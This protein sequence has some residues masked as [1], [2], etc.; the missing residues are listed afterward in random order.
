MSVEMMVKVE[1]SAQCL[2]HH[3]LVAAVLCRCGSRE[4]H[5]GGRRKEGLFSPA[6][7][8]RRN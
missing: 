7:S 1:R 2:T 5:F 3:A 6:C 4:A 8:Q